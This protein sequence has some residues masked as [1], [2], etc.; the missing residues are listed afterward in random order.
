MNL[1]RIFLTG[2]PGLGKT[3]IIR[4]VV[5]GLQNR[6][7]VVGGMISSEIR[8]DDR[9]IGFQLEDVSTHEVGILAKSNQTVLGAPMVGRYSVNLADIERVGVAAIKRATLNAEVVVVDEIGPMELK[10]PEFVHAVEE[11]LAS[12]KS[13]LGT[14]HK[15]SSH[16]L[17]H[18]IR[19]NP[20]HELIQVTVA[21]RNM[22]TLEVISRFK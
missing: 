20:N 11:A 4:N 3:T 10:S 15:R 9:R 22:A 8:E 2:E 5:Q 13:F 19:T 14:L 16:P 1:T 12:R 7:I 18:A 21:N 6:G 17:I